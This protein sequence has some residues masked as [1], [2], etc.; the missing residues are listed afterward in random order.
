MRSR[1][2]ESRLER[3][4]LTSA[5]KRRFRRKLLKAL[6]G[7]TAGSWFI[8]EHFIGTIVVLAAVRRAL[9]TVI[10]FDLGI[11]CAFVLHA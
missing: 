8:E 5:P 11:G 4:G 1:G 10:T 7:N 2:G 6:W 9:I 3:G